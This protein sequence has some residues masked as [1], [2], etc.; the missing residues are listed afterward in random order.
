MY[1]AVTRGVKAGMGETD[2]RSV[3]RS[4]IGPQGGAGLVVHSQELNQGH[5]SGGNVFTMQQLTA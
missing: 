5:Y 4:D 2:L 1:N 3:Q